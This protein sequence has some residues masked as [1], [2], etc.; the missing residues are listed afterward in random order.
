M[1]RIKYLSSLSA[2]MLMLLG[3]CSEWLNVNPRMELKGDIVYA[4]ENGF[5]DVMNGIYL[6]MA[7]GSLY[8]K[9]TCF[10]FQDLLAGLWYQEP[11]GMVR[12]RY[13]AS[14]D[15]ENSMVED[16]ITDIW[17]EYYTVIAHIND[18]LANL[19]KT[20]VRFSYGNKELLKGE[21]YGLRAYLHSEV[22]RL[23]GPVPAEAADA[24][25][26]IPYV[27]E[28]T[29]DPSKLLSLTYGEVKKMVL[30]D[31]DSAE[32]YLQHDP[33]LSASM[34]DLNDP[35]YGN[36]G[37]K[38]DW[39]YY[40]QT[41]FNTYAVDA[42]RARFCQ[43][44]GDREQATVYARK[45]VEVQA[46]E[47][48][49]NKFVLANEANSYSNSKGK[50]LVFQCEHL[51]ALHC[52]NHQDK[53]E[54]VLVG[55]DL[56][57]P[58]LRQYS[59]YIN[60]IYE[61]DEGDIR[62]KSGRYFQIDGSWASCLKYYGN[63]SI[64]PVNMIPL[65]RL[66]EMYLILI[67]NLP[68]EQARG[69]FNTFRQARGMSV[70]VKLDEQRKQVEKEYRKDFFAEGQM[71]Y[72]YKRRNMPGWNQPTQVTVPAGAFVVPKPKGQIVFE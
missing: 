3:G 29:R 63:G 14:Y 13:I 61:N 31:L 59:F 35:L 48:E 44:I 53:T 54:G 20:N 66:S 70:N 43:W 51:F 11:T 55:S 22:L 56:E 15:Y 40:R 26:C 65:I 39:Q 41:H 64:K 46:T 45:V 7:S 68:L 6:Q 72:Y 2:A 34:K 32:V 69:Y 36:A 25:V 5:K 67:E 10:Y 38:D 71:F 16:L 12:E 42:L 57:A 24:E 23:F 60:S 9:N 33:F 37:L 17:S 27:T 21:A 4:D 47:G 62:N 18:L 19:E 52:S 8:G 1:K 30:Q 28:L 58:T 49:G 50:N